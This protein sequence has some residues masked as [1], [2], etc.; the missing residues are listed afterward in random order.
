M[1]VA[2]LFD[3]MVSSHSRG[4]EQWYSKAE[5]DKDSITCIARKSIGLPVAPFRGLLRGDGPES[6]VHHTE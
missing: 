2:A 4:D 3:L 6:S 1:V 5:K